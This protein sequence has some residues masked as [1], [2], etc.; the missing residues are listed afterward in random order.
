MKVVREYRDDLVQRVRLLTYGV[1]GLLVLIA[2]GFWFVQIVQGD[3]YRELADNNRLR[4]LPI[5][6]PRGLML[7]RKG[8]ILVEN[9]PAYNLMIDRSRS[10]NLRRSLEFAGEV[11]GRPAADMTAL[12]ERYR[13]TADFKPVLVGENLSLSQVAR[14]GV[15]NLEH[16]EFEVEVQN[17]RLYRHGAQTAH[18][19]GYLGEATTDEVEAAGGR[20]AGGDLV[21]KKGLERRYDAQL[22]GRDGERVVVVD[23]RGQLLEE[24]GKQPAVPGT[25]L[26]LTLDLD[27]QEEAAHWLDGPEKVGAIVALDPRNGE[28]LAL[29][30][31]PSFN[32]NLF[33]RRLQADD[34][35]ALIEE[36]YN[37]LQDRALQNTYSPGSTFKMV[38][39][40]AGLTE[41]VV[42]EHDRVF[43]PGYTVIYN[44]PFRCWR[45]EGHGSVDLHSA[46]EHSCDVYFYHLGQK[47]GIERI[48]RYAR[49]FGLGSPTGVDVEGEKRGVVPDQA[50]SLLT[51]KA[52]WYPGETISVAI[53]QGP[54]L[55]TPLQMAV[56][57]AVVANGGKRV[58]PHL[59][60]GAAVPP[61]QPVG[62]GDP[63]FRQRL[64]RA[65]GVVRQG[66]WAVVNDQGG[67]AYG[68]VHLDGADIAGKTGSVQVVAQKVRTEAKNLP[69]QYR[70]HGWF[71]SFAPVADPKIVLVV[72]AEHGGGSHGATPIAKALY[73]KYLALDRRPQPS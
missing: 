34:W 19:L 39:A 29:V 46:I 57:T 27:L 35:K 6:A 18:V 28:I 64:E 59:V 54:V 58:V 2:A 3:Y 69:F 62:A 21:G 55:L 26:T 47:L 60:R 72:F 56:M 20:L 13:G 16:P 1:A 71:T 73:E 49:L 31:S 11:L 43:C 5:Q 10:A 23:S 48:A 17:F 15:S 22:R 42:G 61:P 32:S 51:R 14:I 12:M 44:H 40:T 70:D 8:R 53:G 50:W 67:T 25:N 63:E 65:L 7:D 9:I 45:K 33:S 52:P 36:P 24:Y 68:T 38:M 37:P 41:G 4:K 30:S 66:L